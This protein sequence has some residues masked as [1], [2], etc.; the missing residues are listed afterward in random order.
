MKISALT[1]FPEICEEFLNLSVIG[2]AR[3]EGIIDLEAVPLRD[4][5]LGKHK[6]VDDTPYGGGPGMLM[7]ADVLHAAISAQID[8]GRAREDT[9]VLLTSPRGVPF[10]HSVAS[11]LSSWISER[12]KRQILVICGR[13]EGVDQRFIEKEVD[14]ELSLGDFVI[15]G[16]EIA[17]MAMIDAV[18]RLIPGVLGKSASI[19]EES[20]RSSLLEYSQYTKPAIWE[21][22]EVPEILLSGHHEKIE[23]WRLREAI[24]LTYAL[25]QELVTQIDSSKFPDWAQSLALRLQN[26]LKL[27]LDQSDS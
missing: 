22:M 17:A 18:T 19:E 3:K 2:R 15:S 1:L 27:R 16:G 8:S 13:Y 10:S 26:R 25:R 24:E 23:E 9:K 11:S 20:F 7:R 14:L 5:G 12:P 21:E 4:F 6:K